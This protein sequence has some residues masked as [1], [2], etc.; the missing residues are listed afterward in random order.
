LPTAANYYFSFLVIQALS[1]S[2]SSIL[3]TIPLL[4]FYVFARANTADDVFGKLSFTWRTR[5]GS[6][7]PWYTT[8]AVIGLVYSVIAPLMLI[9]MLLTFSLFYVV[10]KNNILCVVRTGDVDSGGLWFP[11]AINQTF[12]RFVLHGGVPDR[13]VFPGRDTDNNV[14]CEAQGIIMTIVFVLTIMYQIWLA[15]HFN[16]LFRY[17][18]LQLAGETLLP[19]KELEAPR[20]TS[21]V[22]HSGRASGETAAALE[23]EVESRGKIPAPAE[24]TEQAEQASASISLAEK[25]HPSSGSLTAAH[26][27]RRGTDME[28]Q[29]EHDKHQAKRILARL[30]RPLDEARLA[31]LESH[32]SRA[33]AYVS[34]AL[35]PRKREVVALMMSDPISKIMMQ[36]NDKLENLTNEERDMLVIVAFT[37]PVLREPKPSVWIPRDDVA[38]SDDEVRRTRELSRDIAIDNRGAFFNRRL[39]VEVDKPPPDM[40]EYTLVMAAL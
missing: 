40:S 17:A 14:S 2:S 8:F 29:K 13:L 33:E 28:A 25:R 4:N 15:V 20:P 27:A 10:I 19:Y 9:F 1:I 16:G 5:I 24:Q 21:N 6:N 34:N 11:S 23:Q 31:E 18:P 38:V 30:N 35:I 32:L 36:H 37:H 39:K 26:L 12:Y 3:Q 22:E 7:I